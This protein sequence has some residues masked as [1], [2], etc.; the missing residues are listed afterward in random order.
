VKVNGTMPTQL[1]TREDNRDQN[2][3]VLMIIFAVIGVLVA[4]SLITILVKN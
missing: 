1:V 3:K 2:R 4:I